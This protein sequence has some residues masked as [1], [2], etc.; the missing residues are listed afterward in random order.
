MGLILECHALSD[1]AADGDPRVLG[2]LLGSVSINS[3]AAQSLLAPLVNGPLA[4]IDLGATG[5]AG[6]R[7]DLHQLPGLAVQM[8]AAGVDAG[9]A[10]AIADAVDEAIA[11]QSGLWIGVA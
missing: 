2:T 10:T 1:D 4:G 8:S 9:I 5:S 7:F 11:R 6:V 3:A